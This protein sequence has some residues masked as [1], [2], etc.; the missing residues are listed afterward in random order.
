MLKHMI[1]G[2]P[3]MCFVTV[4]YLLSLMTSSDAI[5]EESGVGVT[6]VRGGEVVM[7]KHVT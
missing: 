7:A 3:L 4:K 2:G 5:L 6:R 1:V